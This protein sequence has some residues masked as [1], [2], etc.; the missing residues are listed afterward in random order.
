MKYN[1]G[2]IGIII[3][4]V[5]ALVV[6]GGAVYFATKTPTPASQNVSENN[7]VG[8][9]KDTHGCVSS[10][11]YSWCAIK[12]KCLRTWEEKCEVTPTTITPTTPNTKV[13]I[14]ISSA[15]LKYESIDGAFEVTYPNTW[16]LGRKSDLVQEA[17][18]YLGGKEIDSWFLYNIDPV[19]YPPG[20]PKSDSYFTSRIQI[21]FEITQNPVSDFCGGSYSSVL[22]KPTIL[23]GRTYQKF[24]AHDEADGWADTIYYLTSQENTTYFIQVYIPN[25][26]NYQK[27]LKEAETITSTFLIKSL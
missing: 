27:L 1:K 10:A 6:G 13:S 12:N 11:G 7:I 21:K 4:I 18:P 23:N 20:Y 19:K 25:G 3:A 26:K 2:F 9:D 22:C 24:V 17:G 16:Y 8:N 5:V 14:P 15:L